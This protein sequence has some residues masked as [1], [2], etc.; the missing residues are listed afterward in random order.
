[1]VYT[2][3]DRLAVYTGDVTMLRAGLTVKSSTLAGIHE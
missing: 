3:A 2:D 1:M